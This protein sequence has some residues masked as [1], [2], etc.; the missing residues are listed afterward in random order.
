MA[1]ME[2]RAMADEILRM[3]SALKL[4]GQP[5]LMEDEVNGFTALMDERAPKISQLTQLTRNLDGE[6]RDAVN[7]VISAI[8]ELDKEH[9]RVIQHIMNVVKSSIKDIRGGQK[10]SNAYAHPYDSGWSGLLDT[11]Q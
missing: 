10:L 4:T 9:N 3:T 2:A 6:E 5:D 7:A 11:K 1:D 8:I